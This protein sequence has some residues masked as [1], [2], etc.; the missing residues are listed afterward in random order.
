MKAWLRKNLIIGL[1]VMLCVFM[2]GVVAIADEA[3]DGRTIC[4][5]SGDAIVKVQVVIKTTYSY[6]GES[7]SRE[8]KSEVVGTVIDETGLTVAS[9]ACTDPNSAGSDEGDEYQASS[10]IKDVKLLLSDGKE[11]PAQVVLRDK[12]LDLAFIRPVEKPSTP[13]AFINL[14]DSAKAEILDQVL[15]VTRLPKVA[16]RAISACFERIEAVVE[17]PRKFYTV[18]MSS[19]GDEY[20]SPVFAMSGKP[21]GIVLYREMPGSSEMDDMNWIPVVIT[22][23]DIMTAAAQ[24]PEHAPKTETAATPDK[25]EAAE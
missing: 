4:S 23:E 12:D 16:N 13:M 14:K 5:K 19:M 15:T 7:E 18:S 6:G 10:E 3:A 22:A 2:L 24:A 25:T 21:I 17:K 8:S 20:G 1:A 9:L 11:I